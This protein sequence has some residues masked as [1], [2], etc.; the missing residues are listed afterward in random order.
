MNKVRRAK[1]EKASGYL[2]DAHQMLTEVRDEEQD[3][4][5]SMPESFQDT[6]RYTEMED[7]I[8]I[9]EEAVDQI[10]ETIDVL[11]EIII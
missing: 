11:G 10:D 2:R 3:A 5:D 4:L 1:I 7:A 9:L 6:D 8:D